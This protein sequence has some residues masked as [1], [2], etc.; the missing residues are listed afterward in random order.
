MRGGYFL[1]SFSYGLAWQLESGGGGYTREDL[2]R[3]GDSQK[4]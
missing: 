3:F 1:R 2:R 4:Y